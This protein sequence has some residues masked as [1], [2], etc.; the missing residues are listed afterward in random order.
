M[1]WKCVV[2]EKTST[3]RRD[4]RCS[5][6][7]PCRRG[8][9]NKMRP[10]VR[11]T[12]KSH[13]R[14][15]KVCYGFGI[16][17]ASEAQKNR[18]AAAVPCQW[19]HA[20]QAEMSFISSKVTD[21]AAHSIMSHAFSLLEGAAQEGRQLPTCQPTHVMALVAVAMALSSRLANPDDMVAQ[22]VRAKNMRMKSIV[23]P[24]RFW[25]NIMGSFKQRHNLVD[26]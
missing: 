14:A 15:S 18:A 19:R 2:C 22:W 12:K 21:S 4:R 13:L 24:Q 5:G 8:S 7:R 10:A 26:C 1:A 17:R 23:G 9:C 20:L 11:I 3:Y 6:C 25:T 16:P